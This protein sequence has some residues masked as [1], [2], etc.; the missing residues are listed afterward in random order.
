MTKISEI[1]ACSKQ[2][3]LYRPESTSVV[4]SSAAP[5]AS[6]SPR[7]PPVTSPMSG[8]SAGQDANVPNKSSIAANPSRSSSESSDSGASITLPLASADYKRRHRKNDPVDANNVADDEVLP[9]IVTF[10]QAVEPSEPRLHHQSNERALLAGKGGVP[11][12]RARR[13]R[14][15][16]T[17]RRDGRDRSRRGP[18]GE[19]REERKARHDRERLEHE[20]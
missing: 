15:E 3:K 2:G 18:A 17:G 11:R 12:R 13:A 7:P 9:S 19:T 6:L 14:R 16:D 20:R 8:S 10:S 5:A 1:R 4:P